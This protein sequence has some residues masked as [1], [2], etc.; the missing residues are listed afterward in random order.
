M[1]ENAFHFNV[2]QSPVIAG[3]GVLNNFSKKLVTHNLATCS[4]Y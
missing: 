2:H 4:S 1:G 3:A